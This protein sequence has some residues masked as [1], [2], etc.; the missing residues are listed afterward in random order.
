MTDE[1]EIF[2][3]VIQYDITD[4]HLPEGLPRVIEFK[5]LVEDGEV[6]DILDTDY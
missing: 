3:G 2:R 5:C 4:E 6:I 1:L